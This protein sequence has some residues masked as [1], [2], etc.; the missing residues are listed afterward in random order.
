[1]LDAEKVHGVVGF[2]VSAREI[3]KPLHPAEACG[4]AERAMRQQVDSIG[5]RGPVTHD[6]VDRREDLPD[7]VACLQHGWPIAEVHGNGVGAERRQRRQ[8]LLIAA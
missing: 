2:H 6:V 7:S 4:L 5:T 8:L 1:M 3:H